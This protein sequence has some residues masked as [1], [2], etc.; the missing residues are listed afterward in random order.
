MGR[1][2]SRPHDVRFALSII[3]LTVA[4]WLLREY[5]IFATIIDL[6]IRG[7]VRDYVL[8]AMNLLQHGVFSHAEPGAAAPAPDNFRG[9]G[10]PWFLL[11][12]MWL[13][14]D[15]WYAVTLHAQAFIGALTAAVTVLLGRHWLPRGWA[16]AAGWLVAIWPHHVVATASLL[17]EVWLAFLV[18]LALLLS[19][20]AISRR[21]NKWT[22]ASGSVFSLAALTS[23]VSLPFPL[24]LGL[25][26]WREHLCRMGLAFI[27][28]SMLGPAV[29]GLREIPPQDSD[30][31]DRAEINLVQ[32]SWPG[33]HDAYLSRLVDPVAAAR[34]DEIGK[35][36]A[37]LAADPW[38]GFQRIT[39]RM[40]ENPG[41]YAMWYL[42][43]KPFLLWDWDIRLGAGDVYFHPPLHSPLETNPV[44]YSMK[45]WLA[46]LNPLIFAFS[47]AASVI[48]AT[49]WLARAPWAHPAAAAT[50]VFC[51]FVTGVHLVFQAE[52]RYSIAYRPLELLML[53]TFLGGLLRPA[54]WGL[55]RKWI[56]DRRRT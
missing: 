42:I 37:L 34:M 56:G 10:Y 19:A 53:V 43:E 9:P 17:S 46:L 33:Y 52:P 27:A 30:T 7:D 11:A 25:V 6:P 47:G 1:T 31:P 32:G 18:A 24:L 55:P 2:G 14:P 36:E 26:Y 38:A 12:W 39:S 48:L 4:A 15:R 21:S 3:G 23:P 49:G 54:T 35:E 13:D 40:S 28:I 51:L 20:E 22:L 16:F 41:R 50:A 8:Y 44:L 29:W 45:H 5:F